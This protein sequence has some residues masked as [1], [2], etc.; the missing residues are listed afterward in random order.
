MEFVVEPK[1][2]FIE[3]VLI[4]SNNDIYRLFGQGGA[5]KVRLLERK[6]FEVQED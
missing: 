3:R 1:L 2:E 4:H 5:A 6:W